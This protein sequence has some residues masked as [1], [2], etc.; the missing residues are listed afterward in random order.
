MSNKTTNKSAVLTPDCDGSGFRIIWSGSRRQLERTGVVTP[1][2]ARECDSAELVLR[3]VMRT[4]RLKS[5]ILFTGLLVAPVGISA[6]GPTDDLVQAAEKGDLQKVRLLLNRGVD[7]N[8]TD[9]T[10]NTALEKAARNGHLPIV[11]VLL[12]KGAI[13]DA[14]SYPALLAASQNGHVRVVEALLD[15]GADVRK[16]TGPKMG[17]LFSVKK[18]QNAMAVVKAL[19]SAGADVNAVAPRGAK[20]WVLKGRSLSLS[21]DGVSA[22]H[23]A[24]AYS[25]LPVV[26]LLLKNGADVNART[27]EGFTPLMLAALSMVG[28]DGQRTTLPTVGGTTALLVGAGIGSSELVKELLDRGADA[29]ATD[30]RGHTALDLAEQ[31]RLP[32]LVAVL[33]HGR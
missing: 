28:E 8:G 27:A 29:R 18:C 22:V 14:G 10:N 24:A 21:F 32:D 30:E 33:K 13:V 11:Q 6:K 20:S 15:K 16:S 1:T 3:F 31:N 26:E 17:F 5:C 9:K 4:T 12:D 2:E 19:L 7:P 25:Q 23:A